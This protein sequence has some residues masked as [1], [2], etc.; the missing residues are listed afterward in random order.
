MYCSNALLDYS[1]TRIFVWIRILFKQKIKEEDSKHARTLGKSQSKTEIEVQPYKRLVSIKYDFI[2]PAY[3]HTDY[4]DL[5]TLLFCQ[6]V[7]VLL[8]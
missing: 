2:I 1:E 8:V 4:I 6:Y 7:P 5:I 3:T